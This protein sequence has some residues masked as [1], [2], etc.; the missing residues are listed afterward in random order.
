[1][2]QRGQCDLRELGDLLE[3]AGEKMKVVMKMKMDDRS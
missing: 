3:I 2:L 1:L